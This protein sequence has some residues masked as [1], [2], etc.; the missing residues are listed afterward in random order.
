MSRARSQGASPTGQ[1]HPFS[2]SV[3]L[4]SHRGPSLHQTSA[5]L[6][7]GLR[8][9]SPFIPFPGYRAA[10][11]PPPLPRVHACLAACRSNSLPRW[12]GEGRRGTGRQFNQPAQR[13]CW[14]KEPLPSSARR[15]PYLL[16]GT[17]GTLRCMENPCPLGRTCPI[18][19]LQTPHELKSGNNIGSDPF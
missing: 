15:R 5:A 17:P 12:G 9:R 4:L 14:P 2:P 18:L 13:R 3:A 11:G 19:W 6:L 7:P 1:G 8:G 10:G 16:L